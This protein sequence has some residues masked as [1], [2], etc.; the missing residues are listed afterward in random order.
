M[1]VQDLV[2]AKVW[3]EQSGLAEC[4]GYI[5]NVPKPVNLEDIKSSVDA[6]VFTILLESGDVV[7]TS[8]F[9]LLGIDHAGY[10]K[11]SAGD[12]PTDKTYVVRFKSPDIAIEAVIAA[13]VEV[14][15][16]H[17]GFVNSKGELAALYLF[18]IV[19]SWSELPSTD[20]G[21]R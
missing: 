18:E 21:E 8:G 4:V 7:E 16:E 3:V 12:L 19:E 2:G 5:V 20:K 13:R 14:Y 17:L 11:E 6:S 15:G 9:N 10:I 1:K